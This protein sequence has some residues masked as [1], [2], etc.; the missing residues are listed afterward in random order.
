MTRDRAENLA[1]RL[2]ELHAEILDEIRD[3]SEL[4]SLKAVG[5]LTYLDQAAS[6]LQHAGLRMGWWLPSP[7]LPEKEPQGVNLRAA[8]ALIR[9]FAIEDPELA[10]AL[11][12]AVGRLSGDEGDRRHD[13]FRPHLG[14]VCIESR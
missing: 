13:G 10:S 3:A 12:L 1:R 11:G 8:R 9:Y 6:L 14:K 4:L 7:R 2:E 5:V